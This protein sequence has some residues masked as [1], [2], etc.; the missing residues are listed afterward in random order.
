MCLWAEARM[1]TVYVQNQ[2]SHS[3]LGFKTP[4]E[5]FTGKK[6]EVSHLKIFGCL[7]FIHIPKEK[8]NKL[9]PSGKK[10]I[11]VGYC[12]VSKAFRIYIPGHRHIEISKDVTFDE[13]ATLKKS[14]RC[15]LEEV[16]EEEPVIP[17]TAEREVPRA[18]EPVREDVISPDE[19]IPKDHDILEFQEPPQMTILH[20]RKPA[21]ARE[22]IQDGEKYGVPQGTTRQVKRPK[23]FSSYTTLM[24][25]LLV[26]EPTIFEEAFQMKE[27]TDAMTEEYQS[28]IKNNVWE[29]VP[30]LKSKDVVSSKWLFKIKHVADGSNEKYKARFVARGFSQKEGIDYEETFA[31]VARYTSIRTI[32]ALAAK[33]K[34]K[35]H[36]MDVKTTFL[37]GVIEE[38]VYT[39]QPQGFEVEDRKSHVR[40][41]K[42]ALY[43]LKQA[44]RAWY[45]CIDSFLTS[46]GFTKSKADSN[47]YFK[48]MN[49]EPVILLL[50]VDD[51]FLTGE[52]K[53]ITECKKRLTSKFEMKDLGLMHYFLGLEVW[54]N[55]ERIFLNQG[56]YTVKILKRFDMLECK[57]MN[58]PMEAKLKLLA[59]SIDATLY[60]QIIGSLMYLTNTRLDI[61]FAVN[62]LSQF[63][64]EPRHVYL[65]AA[66]HVM[67]YLKCT[68]DCGLS[69]DGDHDFTLCGYTNSDW[70]G[71]V[72]DR[73]NTSGCYF[74]LG[75]TM[76][77]CKVGSNPTLLSAQRKHNTLLR[78]LLATKLYGFESC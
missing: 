65:V 40:K 42:K 44:P 19:E 38:K 28:I 8:R 4:E 63:L 48:V 5:M 2:L 70:V 49:D 43:G 67:R 27:W 24:C 60:K 20:K 32:I 64:V 1:T 31:P 16:Y 11:F 3:A 25:D 41:L 54:Q 52:E 74:S 26:K 30:R 72:A 7:V 21:W 23:P 50:Y 39:E 46:L 69:Y 6:P 45:G 14:R 62:T 53:L 12:E 59:E 56:K 73:K 66:K 68:L 18:A 61:C 78:V 37:N 58:T 10:G 57:S 17:R 51:L 15:Q 75:S 71:S 29:I 76:I 36:Q 22:L 35:L 34:W 77:S 13:D 9:E 47:L 55:P 33:M